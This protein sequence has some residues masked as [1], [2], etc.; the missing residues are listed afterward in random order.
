MINFYNRITKQKQ[1]QMFYDNGI[2][3]AEGRLTSEGLKVFVD[4]LF[5]GKTTIEAKDL[6][7]KEIEEDIKNN[8]E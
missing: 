5:I 8:K 2:L 3:D 7:Q 4:L 1:E 6:I